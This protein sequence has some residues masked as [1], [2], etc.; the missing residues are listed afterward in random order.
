M[1]NQLKASLWTQK[2][3]HALEIR[4]FQIIYFSTKKEVKEK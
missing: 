1:K 3:F 2:I 4:N